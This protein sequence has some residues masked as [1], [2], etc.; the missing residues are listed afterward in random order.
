MAVFNSH[1]SLPITI[2]EES[3]LASP[4]PHLKGK[5]DDQIFHTFLES[6]PANRARLWSVPAPHAASWFSVENSIHIRTHYLLKSPQKA[7][8]MVCRNFLE[9][10]LG[11]VQK[12][13]ITNVVWMTLYL[14]VKYILLV[15][16]FHFCMIPN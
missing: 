15:P 12:H 16:L 6:S 5:I 2:I 1:V 14:P 10:P 13:Q 9:C 7:P 8:A 11:V 3:A 4:P